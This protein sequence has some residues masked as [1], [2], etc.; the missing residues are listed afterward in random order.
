MAA[1]SG[2]VEGM[3]EA[4][5]PEDAGWLRR[6]ALRTL[7][8]ATHALPAASALSIA[9]CAADASGGQ[10]ALPPE[11]ELLHVCENQQ[12]WPL[13]PHMLL[14]RD[15]DYLADVKSGV[16]LS[17]RGSACS[18]ASHPDECQASVRSAPLPARMLLT[19]EGD[20]VRVWPSNAAAVL[21]G[22]IDRLE[23]A[24]WMAEASGYTVPCESVIMREQGVYVISR[25]QRA[26]VSQLGCSA[27]TLGMALRVAPNAEITERN[28]ESISAG[29]CPTSIGTPGRRPYGCL[30]L[31][32]VRARSLLGLHHARAAQLESA[33]VPAFAQVRDALLRYAAP[34]CLIAAARR[35]GRDEV[36]HAR[37]MARLARRFGAEPVA[38]R[39]ALRPVRSL[40]ELA[41]T[42]VREGCVFETYAALEACHQAAHARD[43]TTRGLLR[44]IAC[45]ELRHAA[46]SH[47]LHSWACEKLTQG[48][49][50]ELDAARSDAAQQL[51]A[52][53]LGTSDH[54]SLV[55]LAGVPSRRTALS[56]HR[57]LVHALWSPARLEL[58]Q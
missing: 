21:L 48:E 23:E 39:V 34:A 16:R 56:L 20:T 36:Q 40:L 3:F 15:V 7:R 5:A 11:P 22:E 26:G 51:H 10:F 38:P 54:V 37:M 18:S 32:A 30:D 55:E 58:R 27:A 47:A 33:S 43:A 28:I 19:T 4:F 13:A 12:L 42:N 14:A 49:R 2:F 41:L 44:S 45:D 17:E 46:F 8:A 29:V 50:R 9:A 6:F 31:R 25:A 52:T 57:A 24:L 53:L 1:R 35:A